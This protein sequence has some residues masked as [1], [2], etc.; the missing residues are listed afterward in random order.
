MAEELTNRQRKILEFI[1]AFMQKNGFPPSV[2][3][4][5]AKMNI[6]SPRGVAKHLEALERKGHIRRSAG[7]QRGLKVN[8]VAIGKETPI[9]GRIAAGKPLTAVE[10]LEGSMMLDSAFSKLGPTF[11]LKVKGESM[12]DAGIFDGDLVLVRQQQTA[13]HGDIV[14]ALVNEEATVKYFKKKK[15][16]ISLEPANEAF[17]PIVVQPQ[18]QF[19]IAGKV[20]AAIRVLDTTVVNAMYGKN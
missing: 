16:T 17:R 13:E 11:L 12:K 15:E 2:R 4:I 5:G 20:I 7:M 3:E 9:L 19:S 14:A 10:N 18:D 6:A 1:Q 8:N